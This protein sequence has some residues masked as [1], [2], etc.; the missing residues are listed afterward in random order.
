MFHQHAHFVHVRSVSDDNVI[1]TQDS[2][3][4]IIWRRFPSDQ[5]PG[6]VQLN[7][8]ISRKHWRHWEGP[9]TENKEGE[10]QKQLQSCKKKTS[11][12][13]FFLQFGA[14]P[15]PSMVETIQLNNPLWWG[16]EGN[17]EE[18]HP[19]NVFSE[20]P[21][22]PFRGEKNAEIKWIW[23]FCDEDL[24]W[25]THVASVHSYFCTL[26]PEVGNV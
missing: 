13:I 8:D 19:W 22:W 14:R 21:M 5:Q 7:G 3:D 9:E 12:E 17:L 25:A 10:I 4:L 18:P 23:H 11:I 15:L 2:I 16:K 24:L 6:P 26:L 20:F 1:S